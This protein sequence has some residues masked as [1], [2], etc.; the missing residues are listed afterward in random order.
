MTLEGQKPGTIVV[1]VLLLS[2]RTQV[3]VFGLKTAYPVYLTIRNLPKDICHKLSH[4][5]QILLTYLPTTKLKQVTS[6][7][8]RWRMLL[9]LLHSCLQKVLQPLEDA[10]MDSIIM[11]DGNGILCRVHPL[12]TM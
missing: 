1:L 11:A 10:G 8:A 9:N 12:L 5:R 3:T 2:D 7:A 6:H 4:H